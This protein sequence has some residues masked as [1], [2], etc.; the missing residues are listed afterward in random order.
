VQDHLRGHPVAAAVDES[1][2]ATAGWP[3]VTPISDAVVLWVGDH[4]EGGGGTF[5]TLCVA[6]WPVSLSLKPPP[7][8]AAGGL[9]GEGEE[10]LQ[11][12]SKTRGTIKTK[13]LSN[14]RIIEQVSWNW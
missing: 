1:L 2:P 7:P 11:P 4:F 6:V 13:P 12:T 14:R 10:L 5:G 8:V 9:L 3:N